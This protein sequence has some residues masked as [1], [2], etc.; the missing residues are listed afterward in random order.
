MD[1]RILKG[2]NKPTVVVPLDKTALEKLN[3]EFLSS[4][5]HENIAEIYNTI[6]LKED[7]YLVHILVEYSDCGSLSRYLHG[8]EQ[9][10]YTFK[11]L[12][13]WMH[14]A[15]KGLQYIHSRDPIPSFRDI[16]T[17]GLML[18]NSFGTLKICGIHHTTRIGDSI[19]ASP[20][21]LTEKNAS[22]KCNV[23]SFGI[24]F[25]ELMSRKLPFQHL[26][27]PVY[28]IKEYVLKGE[29]PKLNEI[30]L[31]NC[32]QIKELIE[33]CWN[34]EPDM[35]PSMDEICSKIAH[36]LKSGSDQII[37]S[38][39]GAVLDYEAILI[40][41]EIQRGKFGV[42][43]K[44][45]WYSQTI[46][47]KELKHIINENIEHRAMQLMNLLHENVVH[48]FGIAMNAESTYLLMEYVEGESL[49]NRVHNK[50]IEI[51]IDS[52]MDW[53]YSAAEAIKYLF[54]E[55]KLDPRFLCNLK[56]KHLK[57]ID[58]F[59]YLKLCNFCLA[60]DD[61]KVLKNNL[62]TSYMAP[63]SI[64]E[65]A[66][67]EQ[68][69]IYS[70]GIIFWEVLARKKPFDKYKTP[71]QIM[72]A[73]EKGEH[74]PIENI[75]E[76]TSSS[77]ETF[78]TKCWHQKPEERYKMDELLMSLQNLKS[79]IKIYEKPVDID[80]L[81]LNLNIV[82]E[83][84]FGIIYKGDYRETE[85][86]VK[87]F[88]QVF[89]HNIKKGLEEEV[90]RHS[91]LNHENIVKLYGITYD[92]NDI[93]HLVMEYA[94]CGSL[95]NYL[96]DEEQRTY[97]VKNSLHWMYQAA[98]GINY[99]LHGRTISEIHCN[100]NSQ[101]ML[102]FKNC[103]L[104]KISDYCFPDDR[105]NLPAHQNRAYLA[106]EALEDGEYSKDT[107]I[108]SFGIVFWEVMT[109]KKPFPDL[110]T[111]VEEDITNGLRPD[112]KDIIESEYKDIIKRCWDGDPVKRPSITTL[113]D[114][115][116]KPE[117]FE[118]VAR[119]ESEEAPA[120]DLRD[121]DMGKESVGK[122]TFGDIYKATW[123]KKEIAVQQCT[124]KTFGGDDFDSADLERWFQQLS[125]LNHENIVELYGIAFDEN[126]IFI[127][128]DSP[129]CISLYN[130]LYGEEH[131]EYTVM[132]G[133]NW[134]SQCAKGLNYLHT[135]T[136]NPL[137][138]GRLSP[139]NLLLPITNNYRN[140]KICDFGIAQELH[141]SF[142]PYNSNSYYMNKKIYTGGPHEE[143]TVVNVKGII[144]P[145]QSDIF[146]FGTILWEV[147]SRRR[148]LLRTHHK[149]MVMVYTPFIIIEGAKPIEDIIHRCWYPRRKEKKLEMEWLSSEL[150]NMVITSEK[151]HIY[152]PMKQLEEE[153][154][155]TLATKKS[156]ERIP[157]VE[158]AYAENVDFNDIQIC[159]ILGR[160]SFGVVNRAE[161][162]N[163]T[164]ALKKMTPQT[165]KYLQTIK[166]EIKFLSD[167][168]HKN[169][170]KLYA[171]ASHSQSFYLLMEYAECE[172][173]YDCLHGEDQRKYTRSDGINWMIQLVEGIAYM[174]NCRSKPIIHRDLKSKNLLL[175]DEFKNLKIGDFG[176]VKEL[177]T[178]NTDS[179][180][181]PSYTAPEVFTGQRM[182][183]EKCDIYSFGI[184]LWEV[185]SRKKPFDHLGKSEPM[186]MLRFTADGNRPLLD[187]ELKHKFGEPLVKLIE[188]CW[189]QDP[190]RRPTAKSIDLS[191]VSC[192]DDPIEKCIAKA[193]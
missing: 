160:G 139:H 103:R 56:T 3:V 105:D 24:I 141:F 108:Y 137:F 42:T 185:M 93:L 87:K 46:A 78:I 147:M 144:S 62:D 11:D 98:K 74:P 49:F 55:M 154:W 159:E 94:N 22:H 116:Y 41:E 17:G 83:S 163:R 101:N 70:F 145:I 118:E 47:V 111:S 178:L 29:R 186:A 177:T 91:R 16:E 23:Y 79:E 6:N 166:N 135:M 130:Y 53:M 152:H 134:M 26:N 124:T 188:D 89:K 66:Y 52:A 19:Y 14:Q 142:T 90:T 183:T 148:A 37:S 162:S 2:R 48:T 112:L 109:R 110:D 63:E 176:T 170:V 127:L 40:G 153:E 179:V 164:I 187:D 18:S 140:L 25:W 157:E 77:I 84:Q 75:A 28:E 149:N 9:R 10:E 38:N 73:V 190:I 32:E 189:H 167:L 95:Y 128:M 151:S 21:V 8:E 100:L 44:A 132:R 27:C 50:L 150:K 193:P 96:H 15:S 121:I 20:E 34:S 61:E 31:Q 165:K 191:E 174:H 172:S 72:S 54:C 119:C 60:F 182:Y 1:C 67:T 125:R 92:K 143:S 155:A 120:V 169:I 156:K 97:T 69:V 180:G 45:T 71:L 104:L 107:D 39:A 85:I 136:P 192:S 57:F 76:I 88:K 133:L 123:F 64:R 102:L 122:G 158:P 106:P 138:H 33:K 129:V 114:E 99:L 173:L 184:I 86:A 81:E 80:F 161:W 126:H 82:S 36:F 146:N 175:T 5:K 68:S 58:G 113:I 13:S 117:A 51:T 4:I 171:T 181:T 131:F 65:E 30:R 115:L 12:L 35:R 43:S 168:C 59:T 7:E